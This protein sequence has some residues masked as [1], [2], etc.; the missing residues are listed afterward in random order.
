[1]NGTCGPSAFGGPFRAAGAGRPA[2]RCDLSKS[3][4]PGPGGPGIPASA[5]PRQLRGSFGPG[6]DLWAQRRGSRSAWSARL[7]GGGFRSGGGP[8]AV[9][10]SQSRCQVSVRIL[11]LMLLLAA[12]LSWS[13]GWHL[14]GLFILA[15]RLASRP[16]KR[17]SEAVKAAS[18]R[19]LDEAESRL[20][21]RN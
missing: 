17:R 15:G 6:P 21:S 20:A 13:A 3:Q 5:P 18:G 2:V 7:M 1:M 8:G 10:R 11:A 19:G 12:C 14:G 9:D 16:P 4:P